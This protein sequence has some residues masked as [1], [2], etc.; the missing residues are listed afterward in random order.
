[1]KKVFISY[2]STNAEQLF[3]NGCSVLHD[4]MDCDCTKAMHCHINNCEFK[5]VATFANRQKYDCL[6]IPPMYMLPPYT[7]LRPFD[8]YSCHHK[9]HN[10][11][12][13]CDIFVR[14]EITEDSYWTFME[15]ELWQNHAFDIECNLFYDVWLDQSLSTNI[16]ENR[17]NK[18]DKNRKRYYERLLYYTQ[19]DKWHYHAWGRLSECYMSICPNCG[20]M[21]LY[22]T[23]ALR[24]LIDNHIK[25]SC[26]HCKNA[27]YEY[28]SVNKEQSIVWCNY[29]GEQHFSVVL[30]PEIVNKVL[31]DSKLDKMNDMHLIC[32]SYES[33][34]ENIA[35]IK[36]GGMIIDGVKKLLTDGDILEMRTYENGSM[37]RN[38]RFIEIGGIL[39]LLEKTEQNQPKNG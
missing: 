7:I 35:M 34:P 17:F 32:M 8:F 24:C 19:P 28:H 23:K 4:G 11:I 29:I 39:F 15:L 21:T 14:F 22:S 9:L 16:K 27:T 33:F 37:K 25:I 5:R 2:R 20:K 18:I 12:S 13:N 38:N 36:V 26:T 3:K 6:V 30:L 1:M 31:L 10:L